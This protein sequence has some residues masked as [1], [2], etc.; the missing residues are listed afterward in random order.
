VDSN[1]QLMGV[2][3]LNSLGFSLGGDS[4]TEIFL[5]LLL[6]F[7]RRRLSTLTE[8]CSGIALV[9]VSNPSGKLATTGGVPGERLYR[10]LDL[11]SGIG[12]RIGSGRRLTS[13]SRLTKVLITDPGPA[14]LNSSMSKCTGHSILRQSSNTYSFRRWTCCCSRRLCCRSAAFSNTSSRF[15]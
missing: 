2:R 8:P 14:G 9:G 10:G 11:F 7:R 5:V 1:C 4:K 12:D 13:I 6:S 15:C 3:V